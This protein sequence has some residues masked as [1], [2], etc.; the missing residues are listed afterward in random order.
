MKITFVWIN[1]GCP[2]GISHGVLILAR[3]LEE[4]G[5]EVNLLHLNEEIGFAADPGR[6]GSEL[7][8]NPPDLVAFSFL[9]SHAALAKRL[10]TE[11]REALPK[12]TILCGGVHTTLNPE[13]VFGWPEVDAVGIGELDDGHMVEFVGRLEDSTDTA[14]TPGFW[15]KDSSG[16][17]R[18]RL[19]PL[20]R[21]LQ[22]AMPHFDL[23][24]LERLV[25]AKRGFGEIIAGRGCPHRCRFCQNHALVERY[26]T[27]LGGTPGS[28]PYLRNRSVD[29][30][31]AE[32]KEMRKQAPSLKAIMFGDDRL[33]FDEDWL[34]EFAERYP[35]E[36]GLPFIANATADRIGEQTAA[37][38]EKAGC[39]MIKIG[40]EC[41][42]GRIRKEVLGRPFEEH[43][44]R[45][46]FEHLKR[47]QINT[48]AYLMVGIPSETPADVLATFRFCAELRPDAYRVS[49]FCPFPGTAIHD[50]LVRGDLL[51]QTGEVYGFLEGSVLKWS[52]EMKS[53]LDKVLL[54]HPWL[55]NQYLDDPV[56][57]RATELVGWALAPGMGSSRDE[58]FRFAF[59]NRSREILA[60]YRK[61]DEPFYHAPF[62][63]RGDWAFLRTTRKRPL[64][65][66]DDG[67]VATR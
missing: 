54:V 11:V 12:T 63:E 29:N 36:I 66:V 52:P 44:I 49:T 4:A 16:E 24:D 67:P 30:L 48:M 26:R 9:S 45:G 21:I 42:P 19:A 7:L 13:D 14:G 10:V 64:I 62:A 20:P 59:E 51:E 46:A 23:V 25:R 15:F 6:L 47:H 27:G 57:Q 40:V 5:H 53:V 33:A 17:H 35:T 37:M 32:L 1:T 50:D 34:G 22:Q 8:K 2:L 61:Q 41:A 55:T 60:D 38:L 56:G 43:A 28:W 39:N 18:N 65:N 58:P 31:L 3:E